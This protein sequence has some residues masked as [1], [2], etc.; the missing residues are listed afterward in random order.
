MRKLLTV[1]FLFSF[2]LTKAQ[3]TV[4]FGVPQNMFFGYYEFKGSIK[5]DSLAVYWNHD[6]TTRA[7][8]PGS[9]LFWLHAHVDSTVWIYD[10]LRW[11]TLGGGSSGGGG[12]N[13]TNL[14]SAYRWLNE[15]SQG[16]KTVNKGFGI[17][18]DSL[19]TGE[20]RI[21]ADTSQLPTRYT[22]DSL[23]DLT[24]SDNANIGA[25]FRWLKPGTQE[26]KTAFA[27]F[28]IGLDSS[29]NTNGITIT[30]DTSK[31]S[32]RYTIDSLGLLIPPFFSLTT[33]GG[34]ANANGASY[35]STT[36]VFNLQPYSRGFGGVTTAS[37]TP[38][39]SQ[40]QKGFFSNTDTINSYY[41]N[42]VLRSRLA[43]NGIQNWW[44]NNGAAEAGSVSFTTPV[45]TPG[46]AFF[47]TSGTGRSQIRQYIDT[48]GISLG[49]ESASTSI[50]GNQFVMLNNG[51][52]FI[53]GFTPTIA[54]RVGDS[55]YLFNV[56][57]T[58]NLW[59]KLY[60]GTV[61][62][63]SVSDS[64]L[65]IHNA[66]VKKVA[67]TS[68]GSGTVM[69]FSAGN[70]SPLFTTSVATS[71]TT[72]A[73]TFSL[74]NATGGT[75]FGNNTGSS[76]APA[77]TA[78]PVLGIAGTT[79][80]TIGFAGN[81][82]G[83]VI[84]QPAA[85][86]GTWSLTLPT[87]GGTNN[88][89]LTTNGSGVTTWTDPN[90]I[91]TGVTSFSAGSTGFTPS[92]G[93]TG[94][95]TLAGTLDVDNG[96]TGAATLTGV[97]QGNGTSAVTAITNS[98]T[99]GQ[100]LR[101]TGASTYAWGAV[102]LAN[103][104]AVTGN[105]LVANLNS[106]T[107]ASS[108]TFW[109]GSGAW[110]VPFALTT[111]GSS[112]AATFSAGTLNIPQ[113]SGAFWSLAS[114]GTLTGNN[115]IT[116]N[117]ANGLI[118]NGTFTTTANSQ[119]LYSITPTAVTLR[120]TASDVFSVLKVGAGA[121]TTGAAT[122]K[123]YVVDIV[124]PTIT[125][126]TFNDTYA[127]IRAQGD[128]VPSANNTYSLGNSTSNV[129]ATIYGATIVS[130][131]YTASGG[132]KYVDFNITGGGQY[133]TFSTTGDF[134]LAYS[135]NSTDSLYR[136]QV[137]GNIQ[138][139]GLNTVQLATPTITSITQ[140]GVAGSTTIAYKIVYR[141]V[142]GNPTAA[143][144]SVSTTTA[145]GTL[146][147]SNYNRINFVAPEGAYYVDV[148]RI[149]TNGVSPVTTGKI[150]TGSAY[151]QTVLLDQGLA[152][153]GTTPPT[154]NL[155]GSLG[156]SGFVGIG[157]TS[158]VFR[159]TN[160]GSD[161][162]ALFVTNTGGS[163]VTAGKQAFSFDN[164]NGFVF[165]AANGT[166]EIARAA[167]NITNLTNT[168]AAEKADLIF[169]T[170][171]TAGAAITESLRLTN[172]G[173]LY[174]TALHNNAG[175]VTGTTTQYIASGTYTPTLTG[176]ANVAASTAYLCQWI[177]VGN[178]VTVTGKADIDPTTTITLTQLGISLPIASNIANPQNCA[179]TT[180]ASAVNEQGAVIGDA[181]ND[182]AEIDMTPVDVTNQPYYFTF[183]Y[184]VL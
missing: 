85:A 166:R 50:S 175:S 147:V 98:S 127:A 172:D 40:G 179:G 82:S 51:H 168:A 65:V 1:L 111:T 108:T 39:Y 12:S 146:S 7:R 176:V 129:W 22:I 115:T 161:V 53:T 17:G 169:S 41:G 117:A 59:D 55:G 184:T 77:Y 103:S 139:K 83:V 76:A 89:V 167:I 45:G 5:W 126:P 71:T 174:G 92:T 132:M 118:F 165:Q 66:E 74:T 162:N 154:E 112:G 134:Q 121:I 3:T 113:Y 105:L 72:P 133:K 125:D 52:T 9:T 42:E 177:R 64:I 114:G 32:T 155:T 58:S 57:G 27:G 145:N 153:D 54:T 90:T 14:G 100:V 21:T 157:V 69:D 137:L 144:A 80:G 20:I 99:T 109:N 24:G 78:V 159:T 4:P 35:N 91:I 15:T 142:Q 6:T 56:F 150:L 124:S 36:G 135:V 25:G 149:S 148:Y 122:Q 30:A 96:G 138:A 173:R 19:T 26:I 23:G 87:T 116:N 75:V 86:A 107:S 93:T 63:G 62:A 156:I 16:I 141:D 88:Y 48:G 104:S 8:Y 180:A 49:A 163:I 106:G 158:P 120:G 84:V 44:L 13:N 95:V 28:G 110:T 60:L 34:T 131:S 164:T 123:L 33:I 61:A 102:D 18:L 101:V 47:N 31:L 67:S 46:I 94:A 70:L 130:A 79:K 10:G 170:Q 160:A 81:T 37:N 140:T 181:T 128:I 97:L 171:Q 152:G 68:F 182:R 43:S 151:G 119:S 38:Q 136:L 29:S 143:S 2:L 73:L 11:K 178:V 183:S